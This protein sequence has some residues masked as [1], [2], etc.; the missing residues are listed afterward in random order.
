[1][2]MSDEHFMCWSSSFFEGD[3][4]ITLVGSKERKQWQVKFNS[5]NKSLLQYIKDRYAK[6][7]FCY[8]TG[9]Y[10]VQKK[11]KAKFQHTENTHEIT[12]KDGYAITLNGRNCVPFLEFMLP[13]IHVERKRQKCIRALIELTDNNKHVTQK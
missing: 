2:E 10:H 1:M 7:H 6:M 9:P 12:R 13:R 5:N 11:G 3:G 4:G 8:F